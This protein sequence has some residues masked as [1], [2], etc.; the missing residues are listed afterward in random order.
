MQITPLH[1]ASE[2]CHWEMVWELLRRGANRN[3]LS[4]DMMTPLDSA[5]WN[6]PVAEDC[7]QTVRML[8]KGGTKVNT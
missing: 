7:L 3:A 5:G 2:D 1:K 8:V 6:I 4:S